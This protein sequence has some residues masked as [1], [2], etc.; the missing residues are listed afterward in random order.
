[1]KVACAMC[2]YSVTVGPGGYGKC[3]RELED[4]LRTEHAEVFQEEIE[5][6]DGKPVPVDIRVTGKGGSI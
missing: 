4:H 3:F 5:D 1:M 2:G 6:A